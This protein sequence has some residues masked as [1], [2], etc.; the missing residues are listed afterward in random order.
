MKKS[1]LFFVSLLSLTIGLSCNSNKSEENKDVVK[2]LPEV[3]SIDKEF[4]TLNSIQIGD[5]IL[6]HKNFSL[7]DKDEDEVFSISTQQR[8]RLL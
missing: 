5:K 1:K 3:P 2:E 4:I 8:K 6:E 7:S